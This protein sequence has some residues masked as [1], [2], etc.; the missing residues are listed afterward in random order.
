[1]AFSEILTALNRGKKVHWKNEGYTVVDDYKGR[2]YIM[3]LSGKLC[4]IFRRDLQK[5]LFT[6]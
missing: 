6:T 5:F 3:H 1:M 4:R 2:Y